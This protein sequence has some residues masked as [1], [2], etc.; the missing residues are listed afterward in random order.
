MIAKKILLINSEPNVQEVLQACLTHLGGWQVL[1]ESSPLEGL[2]A[3]VLAQPDAIVFDLS[4]FGMNC[5]TFLQRLR[6]QTASQHIPVVLIAVGA[7]WLYTE[8]LE[9]FEIAGV[10]DY[11]T[12][13]AQV[14]QQIAMLLHWDA[15]PK[16]DTEDYTTQS[17]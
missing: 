13:P 12:N 4:T 1:S 6:S 9:P 10:I 17:I 11:S 2:Q 8:P 5:L 16:H 15:L 7:K 3:A 14:P